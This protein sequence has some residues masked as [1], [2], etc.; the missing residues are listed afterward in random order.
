MG[1]RDRLEEKGARLGETARK[2]AASPQIPRVGEGF[3]GL[4]AMFKDEGSEASLSVE[5]FLLALV[6]AVRDEDDN[7]ERSSRDVFV[8]ARK[9]RRRL[10]LI[11]FGAGPL[12]GVANQIADLYCET[13]TVCDVAAL[14]G[15]HLSDEQI[16]AH[17]LVLWSVAE[18]FDEAQRAIAGQPPVA[19]ILARKLQERAGEQLPE[20]LTRRSIAKALWDVR[21]AVAESAD[22]ATGGSVQTVVFTGHRTK[23]VIRRAEQQ[24]GV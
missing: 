21:G 5:R 7:E 24:L 10:G 16:A 9:R 22:A 18:Q 1:L 19:S 3:S 12:V 14:H 4:R 11:A 13:A 15:L 8:T 17:M 6:R 20:T 23:K 2:A